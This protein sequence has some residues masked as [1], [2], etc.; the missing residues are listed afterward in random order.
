MSDGNIC[1]QMSTTWIWN[2]DEV[3]TLD[4]M[5]S[6]GTMAGKIDAC[7]YS[8]GSVQKAYLYR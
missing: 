2:A 3:V 7:P 6:G 8:E 1:L 4:S 5:I